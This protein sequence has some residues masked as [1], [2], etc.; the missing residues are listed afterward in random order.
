LI[1]G[2]RG[3]FRV[4][5]QPLELRTH[6]ALIAAAAVLLLAIVTCQYHLLI[7]SPAVVSR[8]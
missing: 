5:E 3:I 7:P 8:L 2:V 6:Q 4:D 1:V